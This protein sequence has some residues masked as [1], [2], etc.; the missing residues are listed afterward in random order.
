MRKQWGFVLGLWLFGCDDPLKNVEL[1]AEPRVLGARVEV[2]NDPGRAAPAPGETATVT[3]LLAS[4][5]LEQTLGFALSAC[6]AATRQGARTECAAEPFAQVTSADGEA[7]IA[8][9]S[10]DV[11]A[12]LEAS[13]RIAVQGILCPFGSPNQ[14][15]TACDGVETGTSVTLAL[16]LSRDGDVN[17]NP[18]L[19]PES[20][21]FDDQA[22]PDLPAGEGDCTGLGYAEVAAGSEHTFQVVLDELDRDAVPHPQALDPTRESLQLSHFATAG[23]LSRAFESIAWD[24]DELVR[25]TTWTAPKQPG[26]VRFWLVLRDLRAGSDFLERSVCVLE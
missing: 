1:V 13:G 22:W 10:F 5:A 26:L 19:E 8:S 21:S 2:L 24:S 16:E 15:G 20:L 25:R 3:F 18:T 12:D 7:E 23:N 14:E 9:L 17:L 11:P 4:P 6:P